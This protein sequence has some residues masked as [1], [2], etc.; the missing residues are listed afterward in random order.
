MARGRRVRR[1]RRNN[2]SF[3]PQTS[4][5]FQTINGTFGTSGGTASYSASNTQVDKSLT[6]RPARLT[7]DVLANSTPIV[8]VVTASVS[9]TEIFHSR[10]F[11]AAPGTARRVN[12]KIPRNVDYGSS[13]IWNIVSSG[14]GVVAG[15]ASFTFKNPLSA[16]ATYLSGTFTPSHGDSNFKF[17]E[18][19]DE[20]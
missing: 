14:A 1:S 6:T 5:V 13:A 15:S 10:D 2:N 17:D 8:M 12:L 9:G 18:I 16:S 20:E 19:H 4:V 3:S 11:L 7:V